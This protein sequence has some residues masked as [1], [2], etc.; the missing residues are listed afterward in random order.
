MVPSLMTTKPKPSSTYITE[1]HRPLLV[2]FSRFMYLYFP[3]PIFLYRNEK[4]KSKTETI[5]NP[6]PNLTFIFYDDHD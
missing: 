3:N 6:T 4:E 1:W 2:H 5:L